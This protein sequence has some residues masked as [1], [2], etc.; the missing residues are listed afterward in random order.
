MRRTAAFIRL[1]RFHFLPLPLL[2]YAVGLALANRDRGGLDAGRLL[3]G[4]GI[5]LLAQLS[6]A[7]FNDYWDRPTDAINTRRTLLSGGSGV[8]NTGFLPPWIALAAGI[9]CQIGAL[10]GATLAGLPS[11]SWLLLAG[12]LFAALFYTAPPLKLGWRGLGELT[13]G[14][15]AALIVPQWAYSLQT[16][17]LSLD[18]FLICLPLLPIVASLF[19]AIAA[20]DLP[21]DAQVGKHTLPVIV[22]E[23]RIAWLY[24]GMVSVGVLA[25]LVLWPGRVP[26]GALALGA[27]IAL[28]LVL[29][30][31]HGLRAP[32]SDR[33]LVLLWMIVRAGLVPLALIVI[34]VLGVW[35][36]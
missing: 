23:G 27:L 21:A 1:S 7:Y 3:A 17:H 8:L 13:T 5:E 10:L 4:A 32:L 33:P 12:A 36:S 6:A 16:G 11:I 14:I 29:L 30:A 9:A 15:V 24:A 28:P 34:L 22:G 31:W 2:T 18:L 20:P 25:A 35:L 26:S 19:L